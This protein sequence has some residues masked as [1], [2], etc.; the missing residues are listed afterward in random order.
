MVFWRTA[1]V[2]A[3][4][5]SVAA[6]IT[7][8]PARPAT[9]F[10]VSGTQIFHLPP[11]PQRLLP[12]YFARHDVV[13]IAYPAAVF[14][15]DASIAVAVA[16]LAREVDGADGEVIVAGFSQGAIALAHEKQLL[17]QRAPAQRPAADQLTFVALGD[18]TGAGG[19]L[20]FIDRIVPIIDL[21]PFSPP[22]TP[23][24]TIAVHGEY[25]GW[26]DF[27]DRP[28]NLLSV[29]NALLGVVYVHGGYEVKPGGLDLSAV[30]ESNVT[31]TTNR[32]GGQTT[33][34]L[35]PTPKLPLVQPL[36]NIGVPEHL[37]AGLESQLKPIV[38]AGYARNDSSA[39]TNPTAPGTIAGG[40]L[41]QA[42]PPTARPSDGRDHRRAGAARP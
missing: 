21:S 37:V 2:F 6:I 32:L 26:A 31:T 1:T 42:R 20:R 8:A 15:M 17:M 23:Y 39:A 4:A 16:T 36:R 10:T 34:Y 18:P 22:E 14:G 25:D 13:D 38:D 28:W 41:A 29:V 33:T 11:T 27:P 7:A 24:R 40:R 12:A 19:I 3:T 30:P 9:A 35:I 5:C